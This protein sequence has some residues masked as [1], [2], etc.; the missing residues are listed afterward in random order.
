MY[1]G[2]AFDWHGELPLIPLCLDDW[3]FEPMGYS[4][5]RDGYDIQKSLNELERGTMDKNRAQLDMS[6]AYDIN[7][8]NPREA[9]Q[10]D[11]MQPRSRVGFDGSL[12]DE[13]F[14]SPVPAEVLRITPEIFQAIEHLENTMDHQMGV[15]DL[16]ALARA[17]GVLTAEDSMDKLAEANGP[18]VMDI[19]RN[20]ERF[21]SK[22]GNQTKYII[23]QFYPTRRIMQYVG[24]DKVTPHTMDFDPERL[25][26]SHLPDEIGWDK[27][28]KPQAS[29]YTMLQRAKWF[30][31]NLRFS[32][33]PHTAHELVQMAQ[34]L[35]LIQLRKAGLAISGKTIAQ[36]WNIYNYGGPDGNTEYDRY[37]AEMEDAAT[38]AMR[39]K[40]LVA[41]IEEAG[42]EATPA[43]VAAIAQT[44]GQ[45]SKEGR[46][47]TGLEAPRVVAKDG[48]TRSTISQSGS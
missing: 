15:K 10:Y 42:M 24:P 25:I 27:D 46:P 34:K 41:A 36:A 5:V 8:V 12:V 16:M 18:V 29:K 17:R 37:Y 4:I 33:A 30:C 7:S 48:G 32:I 26:P 21:L 47:A 44:S 13:P 43:L 22:I 40:K 35:G 45:N 11:P 28:N 2:P 19:T 38:H 6:L 9:M 14:K 3:A 20:V 1:D 39:L 31:D 23:P